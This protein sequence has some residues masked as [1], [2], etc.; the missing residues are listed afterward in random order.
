MAC[1]RHCRLFAPLYHFHHDGWRSFAL[2]LSGKRLLTLRDQRI[3]IVTD[4]PAEI[5]HFA[6][7]AA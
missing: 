3:G 2:V 1:S 5:C 7:G 6:E 4:Q